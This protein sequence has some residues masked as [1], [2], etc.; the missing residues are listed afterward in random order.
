MS[1]ITAA[2]AVI[3]ARPT[4]RRVPFQD[5]FLAGDLLDLAGLRLAGSRCRECGIAL[6]GVRRRC[7]NCAS[8]QVETEV[9]A[10]EGVVHTFTVQRYAPPRPHALGADTWVP[11]PV[12]W[13]DLDGGPRVLAPLA[14]PADAVAI[15]LRVRLRCTV[16]WVD[17]QERE[18]VDYRFAP[19]EPA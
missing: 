8:Q 18:V 17:E 15:G 1:P 16:G 5:G 12:A 4:D 6:W 13:V 11:R 10:A 14:C 3:R 9:F 7:E 19:V 2:A